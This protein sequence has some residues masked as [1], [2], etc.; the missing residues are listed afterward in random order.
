MKILHDRIWYTSGKDITLQHHVVRER[1]RN[2]HVQD[3]WV[4]TGDQLADLLTRA[5][6]GHAM[7]EVRERLVLLEP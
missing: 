7:A 5:L 3:V 2:K 4:R 1:V 6:P